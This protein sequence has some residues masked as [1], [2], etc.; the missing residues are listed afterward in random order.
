MREDM[1]VI[2]IYLPENDLAEKQQFYPTSDDRE[3]DG[4]TFME[5]IMKKK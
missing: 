1:S 3:G 5:L 4:L 2:L